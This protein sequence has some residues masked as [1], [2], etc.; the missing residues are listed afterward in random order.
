MIRFATITVA[1]T[2]VDLH[3]FPCCYCLH[4]KNYGII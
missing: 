4:K 2:A 3:N 1:G